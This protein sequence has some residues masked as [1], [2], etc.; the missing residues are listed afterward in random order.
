MRLGLTGLALVLV[1]VGLAS[2]LYSLILPSETMVGG[3]KP[4]VVA[5]IIGGNEAAVAEGVKSNE[6][7]AE[8][9]VAPSTESNS[10]E[11]VTAPQPPAK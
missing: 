8:L 11:T 5:N 6:P 4:E 7:L 9:G 1:I 2:A 10:S 3:G